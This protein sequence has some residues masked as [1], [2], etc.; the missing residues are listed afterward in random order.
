MNIWDTDKLVLFIAFV[1]PGF[2][3]IKTYDLFVPSERREVGKSLVDAVAYSCV[4][5]SLLLW[6][7]LLDHK[8]QWGNNYPVWHIFLVFLIIV[9]VSHPLGFGIR[10]VAE[11]EIF[12]KI[13]ASSNTETLGSR[14]RQW[15]VLL[16][17]Y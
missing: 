11:A 13:C 2:V 17:Y 5:Y 3:S 4:N 1:I 9:C 7:I 8:Y 12:Q 6:L 15:P 14:L 16:D 10:L